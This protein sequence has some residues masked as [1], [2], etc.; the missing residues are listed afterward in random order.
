MSK[1]FKRLLGLAAVGGAVAAGVIY[2]LNKPENDDDFL[3]EFDD[4]F[5]LDDNLNPAGE[6]EYVPLNTAPKPEAEK[7]GTA[8]DTEESAKAEA[9][10]KEEDSPA[11]PE[12]DASETEKTE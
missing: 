10:A 4:D 8:K 9:A 12:K 11:E 1:V 6:R 2:Y 3:D 5:D 7:E